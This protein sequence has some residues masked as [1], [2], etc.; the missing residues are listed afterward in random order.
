MNKYESEYLQTITSGIAPQKCEL[1]DTILA[2]RN[3]LKNHV[4]KVHENQ[5]I[6]QCALCG[7]LT[8]KFKISYMIRMQYYRCAQ[9]KN[10]VK[11]EVQQLISCQNG[12]PSANRKQNILT[13]KSWSTKT[14]DQS[15]CSIRYTHC[16]WMTSTI[17]HM[18]WPRKCASLTISFIPTENFVKLKILGVEKNFV[19]YI[20]LFT[21]D[22][23]HKSWILLYYNMPLEGQCYN[24]HYCQ[25]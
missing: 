4:R 2:D 9:E 1:C 3:K 14:L 23:F 17:S 11:L 22:N 24:R 20:Y 5:K 10:L 12:N 21:Q 13:S 7:K 25:S 18:T 16:H 6:I 19:K 8:S 15:S